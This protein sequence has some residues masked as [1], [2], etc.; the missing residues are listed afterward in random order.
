MVLATDLERYMLQ[1]V[2]EERT[3]RGLGA[4]VLEQRLNLSAEEHSN[5]MLLTSIFSHT[6]MNGSSA[7]D[8]ITAAGFELDGSW[9]TAENLAVQSERGVDGFFDDVEDL[10]IALMNSPGHRANILNGELD[11]IGIGI[12]VGD[13]TYEDNQGTYFSVMATQNFG[14]T[15]APVVLDDGEAS[16]SVPTSSDTTQNQTITGTDADEILTGG[17]GDDAISGLFDNDT[18]RGEDGDDV[19]RG[20]FG[21]DAIFGGDGDDELYGNASTDTSS[22]EEDSAPLS[23]NDWLNN[24][25]SDLFASFSLFTASGT[26]ARV[27]TTILGYLE[28]NDELYGGNGNDLIYGNGGQDL[29]VGAAGNDQLF[30]GTG[31]DR[32]DGGTGDD[33]LNGGSGSD[34]FVFGTNGGFDV[35]NDFDASLDK[36]VL[37]DAMWVGNLSAAEVIDFYGNQA[38]NG[39]EF[40]FGSTDISIIGVF[41][42][43]AIENA[44]EIA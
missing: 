31:D 32:L 3:S 2:N 38:A 19:L 33:I 12:E 20:G 28:G 10:H 14:T 18:L 17:S 23:E 27:G 29:L 11:Y 26:T 1:L 5:W 21:N 8:R 39:Y 13:F 6:G 15:S 4:L 22:S 25:T 35:I 9:R 36:L 40:D 24:V 37:D 42:D 41:T 44:I 34:E 16:S 7:T 30:G 43:A